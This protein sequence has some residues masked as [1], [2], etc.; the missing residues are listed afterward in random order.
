MHTSPVFFSVQTTSS[1]AQTT[2]MENRSALFIIPLTLGE[3]PPAALA[4]LE[5][6]QHCENGWAK[7]EPI[8]QPSVWLAA[9]G[10]GER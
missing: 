8:L 2:W 10:T 4:V 3:F 6:S 7:P 9:C 5:N 1:K